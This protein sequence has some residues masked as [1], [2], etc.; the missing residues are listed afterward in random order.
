MGRR[1]DTLRQ[2]KRSSGD[3]EKCEINGGN[4]EISVIKK[5]QVLDYGRVRDY[6][7]EEV[8]GQ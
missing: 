2:I 8:K 3:A 7:V 5:E 1:S 4:N 6:K